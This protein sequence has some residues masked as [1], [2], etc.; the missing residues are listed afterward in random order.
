M[1]VKFHYALLMTVLLMASVSSQANKVTGAVKGQV[2][3][4]QKQPVPYST[5]ALLNPTTQEIVRGTVCNEK[6]EYIIDKINFGLYLL[7]VRML[8]FESNETE[9]LVIDAENLLVEKTVTLKACSQELKEVVI[10]GKYN[11]VEQSIDKMI[12]NPNASIISASES[13]YEI[14]KKAP[15]ITIDNDDNITLKGKEG[16]VVMID[17]KP[18]YVSGRELTPLLRSLLGKNIKCIEIIES[19][20][21]QYDAEGI[22][23][24]INIKTKHNQA[25]GYNGNIYSGLTFAGKNGGNTGLDL[26]MNSG[27][28]NVYGN[29]SFSDWTGWHNMNFIR[30]FCSESMNGSY[31]FSDNESKRNANEHNYKAG[32]DYYIAK[33]HVVSV[34]LKGNNGFFKCQDQGETFFADRLLIVD[35]SLSNNS[36]MLYTWDNVTYNVNYKWDIDS[37]GRSLIADFDIAQ[38]Y[39]DSKND[40]DNKYFDNTGQYINQS[41]A[42]Q[43]HQ[44]NDIDIITAKLDYTHTISDVFFFETGLKSSYVRTNSQA[45]MIG[46]ITQNDIFNYK[47]NIQ[48]I[49]ISG[50][51]KLNKTVIKAGLRLESTKSAGHSLSLNQE[52]KNNYFKLFPSFFLQQKLNADQ[53]LGFSYSYR[54]GRPNYHSL[55]PFIWTINPY[56]YTQGN[57]FLAPQ[58]A[59][60]ISATHNYKSKFLTSAGANYTKNLFAEVVYQNDETKTNCETIENLGS[61]IELD[62][63]ETIQM[64]PFKCWKLNGTFTGMYK[65][66]N[67]NSLLGAKFNR[68]SFLGNLNNNFTLPYGIIME[69]NAKYMSRQLIGN[70]TQMPYL[71]VDLGIKRNVLNGKGIVRLSFSDIFN[72]AS[73][74]GYIKYGNVDI[75]V[76]NQSQTQR[77]SISFNYHFGKGEYKTRSN[78]STSSSEEESRSKR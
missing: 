11:F 25:P 46:Y 51:A 40:E 48:A 8:G 77:L 50:R 20:S 42:L 66:V 65:E 63:S 10:A 16:I 76:D 7:S 53:T 39:F 49:Y 23:G 62:L 57:P 55:N 18:T 26:N 43:G 4:I 54:I 33:N 15:G 78:R 19:P 75:E 1:K 52:N 29:Y 9:Y 45:S 71:S 22:S 6:G 56:I 70:I 24:I 41:L 30:R 21:A 59:H 34:M 37:S 61:S 13:I 64:E 58:Y 2:L 12:I 68:W 14:L 27:R 35:S 3:D 32:T 31:Q 36:G 38:F 67:A 17:G 28:L 5:V 44:Q 72:T 74:G 69:L 73:P 60:S 47:E